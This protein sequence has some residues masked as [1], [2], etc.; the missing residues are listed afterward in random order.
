MGCKAAVQRMTHMT[1]KK[2]KEYAMRR[3][4]YLV[5][6]NRTGD[7]IIVLRY[8]EMQVTWKLLCKMNQ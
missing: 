3:S 6:K 5:R 4:R 2:W 8:K 1:W 7:T